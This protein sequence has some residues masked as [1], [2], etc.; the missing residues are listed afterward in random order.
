MGFEMNNLA[1]LLFFFYLVFPGFAYAQAQNN[2]KNTLVIGTMAW[3]FEI[4]PALVSRSWDFRLSP[5]LFETLLVLGED[6][7]KLEPGVAKLWEVSDDGLLY[8]FHLRDDARWSDGQPVIADHFVSGWFRASMPDTE[9]DYGWLHDVIDGVVELR[10]QREASIRQWGNRDDG[11][12]LREIAQDW[13]ALRKLYSKS[14]WAE[15]DHTLKVKLHRPVSYFPYL[16]INPA[17]APLPGRVMEHFDLQVGVDGRTRVAS[18]AFEDP[19]VAIYNGPYRLEKRPVKEGEIHLVVNKQYWNAKAVASKRI[20]LKYFDDQEAMLKSYE[21]KEVDWIPTTVGSEAIDRMV[22]AKRR[23]VHRTPHVGTYYY[24]FNCRAIFDGKPNPY[25]D[26]KLR[27]AIAHLFDRDTIVQTIST[28][29]SPQLALV[30]TDTAPGYEPASKSAAEFDIKEA[31]RLLREAGYANPAELGPLILMINEESGHVE[32]AQSLLKN[33][34]AVGFDVQ[35]ETPNFRDF[36]ERARSGDYQLRRAGWYADVQDPSSFL[37]LYAPWSETDSGYDSEVF[38]K[39]YIAAVKEADPV[40]RAELMRRSEA[41]LLED[42]ACVPISQYHGV[43][44]YDPDR[45][46]LSNHAWGAVRFDRVRK[47]VHGLVIGHDHFE[48]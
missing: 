14:V 1:R 12:P 47:V 44:L 42:A 28:Y 38:A 33:L 32:A 21:K 23:D 30:P 46:R 6:G 18:A 11:L 4:D 35:L 48:R 31:K 40:K 37:D 13:K 7:V 34:N 36:L 8:T 17:F 9:A 2:A 41:T 25:A 45:L 43:S 22:R 5:A 39:Q 15:D 19:E 29:H 20:L 27:R 16:I 3:E 24:E 26:P 10:E